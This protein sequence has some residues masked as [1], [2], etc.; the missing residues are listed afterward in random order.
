[1]RR[2]ISI[3]SLFTILAVLLSGCSFMFKPKYTYIPPES[4]ADKVCVK[5]CARAKNFCETICHLKFDSCKARALRT[6]QNKFEGYKSDMRRWGRPITKSVR[7]FDT[8]YKCRLTCNCV[9]SFNTCYEAC[10]GEVIE[11]YM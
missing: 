2:S 5:R 8:G 3:F 4:H 11:G 1:M 7:D 9:V 10:G 6:A